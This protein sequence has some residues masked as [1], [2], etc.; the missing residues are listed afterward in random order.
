[1]KTIGTFS[2]SSLLLI[3]I[4]AFGTGCALQS[5]TVTEEEESTSTAAT[6]GGDDDSA[7]GS[8]TRNEL[9]QPIAPDR[10]GLGHCNSCGPGPQPWQDSN[11]IHVAGSAH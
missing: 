6:R 5:G 8:R 1:M 10:G 9:A 4:C 7:E 3:A 11:P 2:L